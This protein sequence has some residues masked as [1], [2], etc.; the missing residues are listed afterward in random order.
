GDTVHVHFN[1]VLG[2]TRRAPKFERT[3][4]RT[5]PLVF[6]A[7]ADSLLALIPEGAMTA[8]GDLVRDLPTMGI[9][10]DAGSGLSVLIH[11]VA[12]PGRD[13]PIVVAYRVIGTR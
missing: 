3:V 12:R 1:T 13:G 5:L 8:G 7:A 6:G 11:P 9:R 10:L 4:R 2:R